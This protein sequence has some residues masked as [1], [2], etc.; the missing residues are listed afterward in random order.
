[1]RL[2]YRFYGY[3]AYRLY[4]FYGDNPRFFLVYRAKRDKGYKVRS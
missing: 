4:R 3:N 1:M 2:P